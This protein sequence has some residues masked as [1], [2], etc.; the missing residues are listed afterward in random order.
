[1]LAAKRASQI[2][3]ALSAWA[4]VSAALS[5][6]LIKTV[7]VTA[8]PVSLPGLASDINTIQDLA[9]LRKI[10]ILLVNSVSAQKEAGWLIV[11]WGLWFVAV[12]SAMFAVASS[13]LY[14]RLVVSE[15]SEKPQLTAH[16]LDLALAGKLELWKAFWGL[17]IALPVAVSFVAFGLISLL[18]RTHVVEPAQVADLILTPLA[19]SAVLVIFFG[20]AIIAWR[21][22]ANTS[23]TTWRYLA[24]I[25]IVLY[26]AVPLI[27][28]SVLL[29]HYLGR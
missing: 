28:S 2:L 23:R 20:A 11:S 9:A 3:L 25:A 24:K 26:T 21:C 17:Y 6:L 18:K 8:L 16:F 27:K 22:S 13:F 4:F 1:M 15:I 29:S 14:R 19:Y 7:Y 10:S 5:L 12:W